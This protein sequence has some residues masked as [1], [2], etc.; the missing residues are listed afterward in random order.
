MKTAT[1][2]SLL[3]NLVLAGGL[4]FFIFGRPSRHV[5]F[6][7]SPTPTAKL[8]ASSA[9]TAGT[10][11]TPPSLWSRLESTNDYPHYVANL[12]LAGCPEA[13][14][15]DIVRGD[16]HRAFAFKRKQLGL[17]GNGNGPW[18]NRREQQLVA[19]LLEQTSN[20]PPPA[21]NDI[22]SC[23]EPPSAPAT[24][25]A[26]LAQSIPAATTFVRQAVPVYPLAFRELDPAALGFGATQ[27]AAISQVRQQF[28]Q[29]LSGTSQNPDDPAYLAKWQSAQISADNTLR[30]LLGNQA[31]MAY[32]QQHY[33]SWFQPKIVAAANTGRSLEINPADF[34][35]AP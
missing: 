12:R 27:Q 13:T 15:E 23:D 26:R 31:Y 5:K 19:E 18:S 33:Y 29:D 21:A 6:P 11:L 20:H 34:S 16:A 35:R 4:V 22:S 9:T 14:L 10:S 25:P 7:L 28:I 30:G 32:Q 1:T 8:E 17:A 3:L 24:E 2:A